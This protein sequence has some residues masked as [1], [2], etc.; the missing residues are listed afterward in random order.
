VEQFKNSIAQKGVHI[1]RVIP[2]GSHA[3]NTQRPDSDIDLVVISDSFKNMDNRQCIDALADAISDIFQPIEAI[4][5]ANEEWNNKT[6][7]SA[8]YA[9]YGV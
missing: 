6:F 8:E 5:M 1:D 4:G 7:I 3:N 9:Q 2:Y